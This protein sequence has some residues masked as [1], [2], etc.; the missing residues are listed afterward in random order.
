MKWHVRKG[1]LPT[2]DD[3]E[4]KWFKEIDLKYDDGEPG[5]PA[6]LKKLGFE[7]WVTYPGPDNAF[8]PLPK[9]KRSTKRKYAI[10]CGG[11]LYYHDVEFK[12]YA[13]GRGY[14]I[15]EN[16]NPGWKDYPDYPKKIFDHKIY[17]EWFKENGQNMV[18]I[19]ITETPPEFNPIPP[20]PPPPPPPES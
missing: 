1:N 19:Y 10:F 3:D 2:N 8:K 12:K 11:F 4:K 7:E 14:T 6:E 9:I 15:D 5:L 13:K 20:K 16:G 18:R 17:F